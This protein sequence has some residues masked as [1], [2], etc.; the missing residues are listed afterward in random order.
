MKI[1]IF[2]VVLIS[3]ISVAVC[4]YDKTAAK[5]SL[6]RIRESL[7]FFLSFIGGAFAMYIT[8]LI[9]R[10]KTKHLSFM[11]LLPLMIVLHVILLLIAYRHLQ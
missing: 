3:L 8:M 2:Y 7:L 1:F 11:V 10:H 9:I 4:V 6:H 5:H